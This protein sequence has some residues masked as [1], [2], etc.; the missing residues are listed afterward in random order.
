MVL[1]TRARTVKF[2]GIQGEEQ[3]EPVGVP[4]AL[5]GA[6]LPIRGEELGERE[7]YASDTDTGLPAV[8]RKIGNDGYPR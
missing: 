6:T 4:F 5:T 8:G 2:P 7:G 3:Q 1:K